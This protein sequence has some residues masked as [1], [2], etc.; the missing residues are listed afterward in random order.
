MPLMIA[1]LSLLLPLAHA[2]AQTT[3][4]PPPETGAFDKLSP[5]GQKIASAIF[6]AQI[7]PTTPTNG[8]GTT[9]GTNGTTGV[10]N[11]TTPEPLTLDQIAQRKLD[12]QGWG[13]IFKDLKA[14]GLVTTKNLGQA[15]SAYNH[16]HKLSSGTGVVTTASGR[17]VREGSARGNEASE[18]RGGGEGR[19]G[20]GGKGGNGAGGSQASYSNAGHGNSGSHASG[21]G[22]G[23]RGGGNASGRMK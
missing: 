3:T 12:G 5:G 10:T 22:G 15:V 16:N 13:V 9:T 20:Q 7:E 19:G 1:L 11:G 2:A 14:Q 6:E 21:S 17:T 18:H 4:P 8:T 23:N